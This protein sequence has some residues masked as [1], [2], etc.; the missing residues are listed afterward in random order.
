M[1]IRAVDTPPAEWEGLSIRDLTAGREVR[2][3]VARIEAPP[4]ARHARSW[5]HRS[6]KFYILFSGQLHFLLDGSVHLLC[7]GDLCLVPQGHAFAYANRSNA[8][9]DM[10]LV[11]TPSFELEAEVFAEHAFAPAEIYHLAPRR[12][13]EHGQRG[14]LYAPPAFE[15]DGFIH[16]CEAEQIA[17]V[18]DT[19]YCGRKDMVLLC[20]DPAAVRGL[21]RYEDLD[22]SGTFFP[23]LYGALNVDAVRQVRPLRP[24][25]EGAFHP[26]AAIERSIRE[27]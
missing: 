18:G 8:P 2:S 26:P 27:T 11:H 15:G 14:G 1:I 25:A 6:D 21:L 19:Y 23:H 9:V 4:G 22:G 5:S 13:W 7:A 16:L 12:E 20:V 10:L 3:S 24:D 17:H